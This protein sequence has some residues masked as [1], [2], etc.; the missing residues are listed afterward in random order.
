VTARA[1]RRVLPGFPLAI[2][3]TVAGTLLF[4]ALP[5]ATV[6]TSAARLAP[7]RFAAVALSP[8]ALAAYRLS[9]SASLSAAT[10]AA[11][12]GLVFAW[13]LTRYRFLGH[14]ALDAVLDMP[15]ALPTA[16]LGISLTALF[17][18][19]G[20]LGAPLAALGL[21]V[22]FTPVGIVIALTV[23]GLPLV[24]RTVAPV[25]AAQARETEEAS[26]VLGAT[27]WQTVR[28]VT[29]PA[30]APAL[31]TGA[32]MAF[33]RGVGE[34]GS[35]VFIAGNMPFRT[36]IAPLLIMTRIEEF[37]DGAAT[38][39]ATM[40]LVA[41]F[42]VLVLLAYLHRWTAVRAGHSPRPTG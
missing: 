38:A 39:V 26:A 31:V 15:V 1:H 6:L 10:L 32:T 20:W 9:F 28:R 7:A 29:L 17:T 21:R 4:V 36:E 42:A 23:L 8:R 22:A 33:A 37:D 5:L 11:T 16:V 12:L 13:V 35:I 2:S 24:V 30:I 25:L 14:D 40:L 27:R 3:I 19:T 18:T 41:S 34:Y